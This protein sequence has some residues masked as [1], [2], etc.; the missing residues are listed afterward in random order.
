MISVQVGRH[1]SILPSIHPCIHH[2]SF[3]PFIHA[4]M[5][6][7]LHPFVLLFPA[8]GNPFPNVKVTWHLTSYIFSSF[9]LKICLK[10][11]HLV[12]FTLFWWTVYEFWQVDRVLITSATILLQS[13]SITPSDSKK[14]SPADSVVRP[15]LHPYL[16]ATTDLFL[17]PILL[18]FPECPINGITWYVLQSG[19]F[20]L[21]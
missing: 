14:S 1:S 2:A 16:S 15:W 18:P 21:A 13:R 19:F 12:K 6:P 4:S 7:S 8:I 3:F 20:F 11:L 5:H 9:F 10:F 17:V